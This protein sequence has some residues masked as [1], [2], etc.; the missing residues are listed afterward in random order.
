MVEAKEELRVSL[1]EPLLDPRM[2]AHYGIAPGAKLLLWGPPGCGKTI[3]AR[4]AAQEAEA[5]FLPVTLSDILGSHIGEDESNMTR[6]FQEAREAAP[7]VLFFDEA[8]SLSPNR[9]GQGMW[10]AERRLTNAFLQ[11]LD[12]ARDD[13]ESVA[14]V[15]ATNQPWLMDPAVRRAGRFDRLIY[16]GLPDALAR[17]EIWDLGLAQLP[18]GP[19]VCTATLADLSPGLAGA[20]IAEVVRRVQKTAFMEARARG[21]LVDVRMLDFLLALRST[22]PRSLDWFG[23]VPK[24]FL[25]Q[26]PPVLADARMIAAY[27]SR[28]HRDELATAVDRSAD[29]EVGTWDDFPDA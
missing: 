9:S 7:A 20:E 2:A 4:A 22:R 19:D 5:D 1:I 15:G 23:M 14:V 3:F 29:G 26:E 12:G 16:I 27:G 13:C 21:Q 11:E 28:S 17:R 6:V 25:G 8:D 24:E 10:E 18:L